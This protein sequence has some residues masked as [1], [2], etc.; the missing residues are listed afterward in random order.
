[1]S[2]MRSASSTT[3]T[4]TASSVERA[5][6]QE[7]AESAGARDEHVDTAIELAMLLSL[8]DPSVHRRDATGA[9]AG[10]RREVAG[11]LRRQLTRRREDQRGRP[12]F[13]RAADTSQDRH[14]E[15]DRL[16]GAGGRAAT[17][18][19]ARDCIGNCEGLYLERLVDTSRRE[20]ADERLGH[21]ELGE[22]GKQRDSSCRTVG[23]RRRKHGVHSLER[24]MGNESRSDGS[25]VVSRTRRGYRLAHKV[26]NPAA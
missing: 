7:V 19:A 13:R 14:T 24:A 17:D 6:A 20:C 25:R 9:R 26:T 10:Q 15:R 5:L 11:D 2:A 22:C 12:A 3:T 23:R 1:M 4:S 21:A 16:A 18:V 8:A